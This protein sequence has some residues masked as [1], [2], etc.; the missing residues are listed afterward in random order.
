MVGKNL[1]SYLKYSKAINDHINTT[2]IYIALVDG[3]VKHEFGIIMLPLSKNQL[4]NITI[5]DEKK[6]KF[7]YTEYIKLQTL[8]YKNNIYSLL[9]VK[10]KTGRTHQIRIHLKAIGHKIICDKKYEHDKA[11]LEEQCNLSSRLFLHSQYYKV[12]SDID[13]FVKIPE[14]LDKTLNK[15]KIIKINTKYDNALDILKSNV[16]TNNFIN[17]S[18]KK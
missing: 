12:E 10:I 16:I 17:F 18:K 15:L 5:V 11:K 8:Q 2:K 3:D 4:T 13:G 9:L 14:D 6:G 1:K 7:A